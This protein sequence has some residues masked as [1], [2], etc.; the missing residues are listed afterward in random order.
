MFKIDAQ[1]NGNAEDIVPMGDWIEV[2][3][4]GGIEALRGFQYAH[5]G[6]RRRQ[7]CPV[8]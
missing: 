8:F 4:P 7:K 2:V 6:Y 1:H 5:T 3:S